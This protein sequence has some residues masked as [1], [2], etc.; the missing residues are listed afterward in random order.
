MFSIIIP[1]YNKSKYIKRAL[2]SVMEQ[3][4]QNYEV[5]VVNDGSTDGGEKIVFEYGERVKL[6]SQENRGVSEA[7]NRGIQ[8]SRHPWIAF[9]DADDFWRTDY[10]E[11]MQRGI[12]KFPTSG[13]FGCSYAQKMA[14]F[15]KLHPEAWFQMDDY[16]KRAIINTLFF[17]SATVIRKSFFLHNP[18]FDKSLARGEDLDVWFRAVLFFERPVYNFS[19]LVFYSH[20]DA[21]QATNRVFPLRRS[22]SYKI[23]RNKLYS[24][25]GDNFPA[26]FEV[27]RNR[28]V[29]FN[30]FPYLIDAQNNDDAKELLKN[31]KREDGLLR[32]PY[33]PPFGLLRNFMKFSGG[34]DLI[35]NYLKFCL[36]Y[37]YK[38]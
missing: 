13:I 4:F 27:F 21:G 18:G 10:L 12:E 11:N 33:C 15:G 9:L 35:R 17:T 20:E 32:I 3:T 26:D 8:E 5:I 30:L 1:L 38:E 31:L 6:I 23:L 28:Y 2:D 19:K 22:L 7:R 16:F 37:I 14:E 24:G 34:R 25:Y 29:Y 36:R